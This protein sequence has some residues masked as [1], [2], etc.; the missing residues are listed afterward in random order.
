MH[1]LQ[2]AAEIV[3]KVLKQQKPSDGICYRPMT[4]CVL[5][6][7]GKT[8]LAYNVLTKCLISLS[9]EESV[10][11]KQAH[12]YSSTG[13]DDCVRELIAQR[14]LVPEEH[15]DYKL[16]VQLRQLAKLLGAR[17]DRIKS[18][19]ILTTTDCN[20]RCFYCY[21]KGRKRMP[22]S[23]Q[24]AHDV[25]AYISGGTINIQWFGGEPLYNKEAIDTICQDLQKCGTNYSASMITNAYLFDEETV[26]RAVDLWHLNQV[27]VTLDGTEAIYNRC[28][29]YIYKEGSAYRRVL[30]N[31]GLLLDAGI[32][33][34][35]RL[36]IDM[37]NVD[38]LFLLVEDLRTCFVEKNGLT[39]YTHTIF[40]ETLMQART[41]ERR[42]ELYPRQDQLDDIIRQAGLSSTPKLFTEIKV[43]FCKVD[44]GFSEVILPDGH[45]GLCEHFTEDHYVGHIS[46]EERDT[47]SINQQ[48]EIIE[49]TSC[50]SCPLM[51]DCFRLKICE[52]SRICYPEDKDRKLRSIREAMTAMNSSI[53][54][55][56][57]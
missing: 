53:T 44:S 37:H 4:Y 11:L 3:A 45:I 40:E 36:N 8:V 7:S 25:A 6:E 49:D 32:K 24:T 38:D 39:V 55:S 33:V 23:V 42:R 56:I 30:R 21:E 26:K 20:A 48:R 12:I 41:D 34:K 10:H 14:F 52:N 54:A 50:H 17:K 13:T 9:T 47:V 16:C 22:M 18:Y 2:P 31:I 19:T 35:V 46:S 1:V 43:N 29:A 28:K 51:P 15:N 5:A 27:Q 57:S